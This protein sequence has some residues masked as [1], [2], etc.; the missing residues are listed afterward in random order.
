M[1]AG[2]GYLMIVAVVLLSGCASVSN[3][4]YIPLTGD[5]IADGYARIDQGRPEDRILWQYTTALEQMRRGQ[6]EEAARL[7]D[8]ALLSQ[9]AAA[10]DG[11]KQA[12]MATKVFY[13]ESSKIYIGEPYERAMAWF[14]RGILYWMEGEPD[15]ARA[16]FRSAQLMDGD[17]E[18]DS[19]RADYAI[20]DYMIAMINEFYSGDDQSFYRFAR[21]NVTSDFFPEP[22]D[23]PNLIVVVEFGRGPRK[24]RSGVY[25]EEL[26]IVEGSSR[27]NSVRATLSTGP[28]LAAGP[29]DNL[30]WQARTRGGRIMDHVLGRKAVFK[31][32]TSDLGDAAIMSG[33]ILGSETKHDQTAL[34]VAGIGIL[35]KLISAAAT[36]EADVRQW[37]TLPQ[38]L[39][40]IPM[41]VPTGPQEAVI[42]FYDNQGS[43]IS[44]LTKTAEINVGNRREPLVLFISEFSK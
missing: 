28:V 20:F 3:A 23:S 44:G 25:G 21:E 33:I 11:G 27:V 24:S 13:P 4:P 9:E 38:H 12:R 42:Q 5:P 34:T 10:T 17:A 29:M 8:D 16:C 35:S 40:I 22:V 1:K 36:P 15:N 2:M 18:G 26:K 43:L 7:L 39:T 19:Y 32:T 37:D 30:S 14:Y 6:F 41:R 31:R